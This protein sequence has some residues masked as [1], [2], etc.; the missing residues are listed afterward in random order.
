MFTS[1]SGLYAMAIVVLG[2][3]I[4]ISEIFSNETFN[5][6]FLFDV[7]L[8][9]LR[10]IHHPRLRW[11]VKTLHRWIFRELYCI[12]L[13]E[14]KLIISIKALCNINFSEST[15]RINWLIVC[16]IFVRILKKYFSVYPNRSG[17]GGGWVGWGWWWCSVLK[18]KLA[19]WMNVFM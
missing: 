5:F 19:V 13:Y 1:I 11:R 6:S 16:F 17:V 3:V 10:F 2:C 15:L 18:S 12:H 8:C 7:R 9:S 4:P 14:Q